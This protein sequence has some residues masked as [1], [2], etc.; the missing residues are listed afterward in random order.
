[1][2]T[3]HSSRLEAFHAVFA[4]VSLYFAYGYPFY[5]L[6]DVI[7][8]I[9]VGLGTFRVNVVALLAPAALTWLTSRLTD[10]FVGDRFPRGSFLELVKFFVAVFV[11]SC[12]L[13]GVVSL[14][15]GTPGAEIWP[16]NQTLELAKYLFLPM[17][18]YAGVFMNWVSLSFLSASRTEILVGGAPAAGVWVFLAKGFFAV[19]LPASFVPL[20]WAILEY[21]SKLDAG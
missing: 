3:A 12:L 20:I 9:R 10:A 15:L 18:L 19:M 17:L 8:P 6:L 2:V 21:A 13:F 7:V 14:G 5:D 16:R 4:K 1:M 11:N